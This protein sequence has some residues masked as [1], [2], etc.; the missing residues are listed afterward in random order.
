MFPY[1]LLVEHLASASYVPP[2]CMH[3]HNVITSSACREIR[4]VLNCEVLYLDTKPHRGGG[5]NTKIVVAWV[6]YKTVAPTMLFSHGNAVDLGQMLP[7]YR[8]ILLN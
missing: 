8:C 6:P 5:G 3:A 4:K 7:F 1:V 2:A